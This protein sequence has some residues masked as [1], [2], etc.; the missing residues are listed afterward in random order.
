MKNSIILNETTKMIDTIT[1]IFKTKFLVLLT[2]IFTFFAPVIPFVVTTFCFIVLDTIMGFLKVKY[3]GEKRNSNGF[4]RG[5][6]PKVIIYTLVLFM[7]FMAD[8]LITAEPVKHYT[9]FDFVI[10]KIVA[11]IL[12]FIEC[13]SI[14][15][16][17]KAIFNVSIINK[18][19]Q[20]LNYLKSIFR[21][22]L[23]NESK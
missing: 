11:L 15:E 3:V 2:L 5:F 19:K 4:K 18:F 13:W 21:K 16:N 17:F 9:Q 8:K 22:F 1:A 10:T 20:F 14:D 7:V 12:I 23:D 6:I